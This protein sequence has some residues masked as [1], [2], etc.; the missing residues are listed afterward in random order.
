MAQ[1]KITDLQLRD[2]VIDS[3]NFPSDDS[4]QSYRV[5]AL[6]IF[7]YIRSKI[8]LPTT[9]DIKLTIK[10]TSDVGWIL[11]ND[12]TI[13]NASSGATARANADCEDLYKLIWNNISNTHAPVTGG[14]G[15]NAQADFDANKPIALT[16]VLGRAL[17]V[18]GSGA[19]LTSRALGETLGF[20]THTLTTGEMPSHTHTQN[21]HTHTQNAH[22]HTQSSHVHD[23]RVSSSATAWFNWEVA[24]GAQGSSTAGWTQFNTSLTTGTNNRVQTNTTTAT[25][26]NT[27]ATNQ[28]TTAT[29]QNTGGNGA[30]NNMQPT[31][32]L[33]V[34]IKL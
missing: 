19:S 23:Q 30:H 4:I 28:D 31:S 12:G 16:K 15:V 25:N 3:L 5:T 34:M 17:A 14:R 29:N 10:T 18:A 9:G 33:N 2:A 24:N 11:M 27:T 22:T 6:Q 21:A 7:D 20:E 1:K 32:F 26:Q 8:T 13:G